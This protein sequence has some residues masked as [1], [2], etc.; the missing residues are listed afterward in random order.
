MEN[1][2][3][4]CGARA[5]AHQPAFRIGYSDLKT[6]K[7]AL[8]LRLE[9]RPLGLRDARYPVER[10]KRLAMAGE[11]VGEGAKRLVIDLLR[12]GIEEGAQGVQVVDLVVGATLDIGRNAFHGLRKFRL[13]ALTLPSVQ[14]KEGE[15]G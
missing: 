5:C 13:R 3:A 2:R 11:R 14:H 10:Q 1:P 15:H 12:E 6:G 9:G 7:H 8:R 4:S